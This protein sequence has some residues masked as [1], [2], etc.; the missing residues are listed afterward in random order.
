MATLEYDNLPTGIRKS[1]TGDYYE[2]GVT[3][4]GV[5]LPFG[6]YKAGG[7]DEDLA[8]GREQAAR[9]A[10]TQTPEPQTTPP[11]AL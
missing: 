10:Q 4:E 9:D 5:F 6:A 11:S 1:A 3:V 2:I 8:E 7:F